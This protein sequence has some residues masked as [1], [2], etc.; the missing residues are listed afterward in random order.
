MSGETPAS[1]HQHQR[2]RA[3]AA[4][5]FNEG[6]AAGQAGQ[7]V[8]ARDLFAAIVYWYPYDLEARNALALACLESGDDQTARGHWAYILSRRPDD[9][10]ALRGMILLADKESVSLTDS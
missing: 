3:H 5:L 8:A 9:T 2:I 7:A 4:R 6:L 1:V 10:K